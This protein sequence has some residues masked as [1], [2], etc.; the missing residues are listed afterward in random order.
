MNEIL[1]PVKQEHLV[2]ILNGKK[3]V[4]IR[5]TI[6]ICEL[7]CRVWLFCSK[8]KKHEYL[9]KT[10]HGYE[11]IKVKDGDMPVPLNQKVV[12]CFIL[13]N[14]RCFEAQCSAYDQNSICEIKGG[15]SK[16]LGE[17]QN[18]NL[19]LLKES[20]LSSKQLEKY[21]QDK[22]GDIIDKRFYGWCIDDLKI[23]DKPIKL[24]ECKFGYYNKVRAILR[25]PQ[26]WCYCEYKED[27][28][29]C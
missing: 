21:I 26:S 17:L 15:Y 29:P 5:T 14:V 1:L 12:G 18:P 9:V 13:K 4:E 11:V 27:G 8:G 23:L 6:P 16:Y 20:C 2:N 24:D 25:A 10:N 19:E 3:T 28:F 7:P 22:N